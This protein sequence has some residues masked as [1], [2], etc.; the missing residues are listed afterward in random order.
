MPPPPPPPPPPWHSGSCSC[1]GSQ[2]ISNRVFSHHVL[3][4]ISSSLTILYMFRCSCVHTKLAFLLRI[5]GTLSVPVMQVTVKVHTTSIL[6]YALVNFNWKRQS[7]AQ[8]A[9]TARCAKDCLSC[10]LAMLVQ[11]ELQN[12]Q[13]TAGLSPEFLQMARVRVPSPSTGT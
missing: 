8:R 10:A 3:L 6:Q 7:V 11:T 4:F 2:S 12:R 1:C 9:A 13:T 5:A